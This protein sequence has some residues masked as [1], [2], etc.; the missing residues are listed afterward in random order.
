MAQKRNMKDELQQLKAALGLSVSDKARSSSIAFSKKGNRY[1]SGQID[2]DTGLIR[3]A[4]EQGA[5]AQ[6][7]AAADHSI[8]KMISMIEVS[9]PG[10]DVSPLILKFLSDHSVRTGE[11]ISYELFDL[12]GKEIFSIDDVR[13]ALPFYTPSFPIL[14]KTKAAKASLPIAKFN[15]KEGV[16]AALK[17]YAK[18][19]IARNFAMYEGA[20]GYGTAVI[21][22]KKNIYFAGQYSSFDRRLG[23][24]SEMSAI[25]LAIMNG[26][27]QITHL[28]VVSSKHAD[29]ACNCCG[30]CRQF[31]AEISA[32]K[33]LD[34]EIH[35]FAFDEKSVIDNIVHMDRYLPAQWTNKK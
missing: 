18:E 24:H 25:T 13:K 23:L 20:S 30:I 12:D 34:I 21:T 5:L 27:D 28:G 3:I 33:S 19:G 22:K 16:S 31:I 10:A 8:Y 1:S 17:R 7:A 14:E 29:K 4:S 2:A 11:T 32:K 6:A 9:Q 26:D 15:A 35:C